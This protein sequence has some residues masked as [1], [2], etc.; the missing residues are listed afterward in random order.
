MTEA[1]DEPKKKRKKKHL[2]LLSAFAYFASLWVC[3]QSRFGNN[4]FGI[5][6]ILHKKESNKSIKMKWFNAHARV[7]VS[8]GLYWGFSL[9]WTRSKYAFWYS[10]YIQRSTG[11]MY[12]RLRRL[13]NWIGRTLSTGD[14]RTH[15]HTIDLAISILSLHPLSRIAKFTFLFNWFS[16][17]ARCVSLCFT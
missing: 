11:A 4:Y 6:R 15:S 7:A 3:A 14:S 10:I 17:A 1:G 9:S 13:S 12:H 2:C 8:V 16:S 5:E